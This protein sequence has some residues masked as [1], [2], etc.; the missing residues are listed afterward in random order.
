MHCNCVGC[1]GE[2]YCSGIHHK[3][4]IYNCVPSQ[5]QLVQ[6]D[7]THQAWSSLRIGSISFVVLVVLKSCRASLSSAPSRLQSP[8]II[9]KY[10]SNSAP[11]AILLTLATSS[12]SRSLP[13][14]L[15][16]KLLPFSAAFLHSFTKASNRVV[17]FPNYFW[18]N[19]QQPEAPSYPFS[20][21]P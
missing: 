20:S 19:S 18:N 2:N 3:T 4:H 8:I 17:F 1:T 10:L 16:F 7:V 21:T 15:E 11:I 6:F 9:S 13:L 12:F 5:L 14:Y